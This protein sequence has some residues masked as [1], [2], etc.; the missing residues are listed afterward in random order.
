MA[1]A[2]LGAAF[3]PTPPAEVQPVS[4]GA[5]GALIFRVLVNERWYLLRIETRADAMRNPHQYICL[6]RAA[7]AG[8]APPVRLVDAENGVVIMDFLTNRPLASFPGGA[9]ALVRELGALAARLQSTEGFPEISYREMLERM[10][11][12]L[13]RSGL[14]A[15][16]VLGPH[17]AA[18]ERISTVYPWHADPLVASHND[19]N[20]RNILFD[21]ERLWLVDWETAYRNDPMTDVAIMAENFAPTD[22]L[23]ETLL[24]A[25]RRRTPDDF[26]RAR[27]HVMRV[28]TRLYYAGLILSPFAMN[29]PAEPDGDLT[30]LTPRQLAAE[31]GKGRLT[32]GTAEFMYAFGKMLLGGFLAGTRQPR[33]EQALRVLGGG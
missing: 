5:S 8:I 22:E 23:E 33:F 11:D 9:P 21:G 26:I 12:S 29:P 20:A 17:A 13:Q 16:D 10:T 27:L 32:V 30:H 14:F 7:D 1:A 18:L 4:G 15:P 2:A 3:G 19:P 6:A 25:W 31:V 28:L 24:G